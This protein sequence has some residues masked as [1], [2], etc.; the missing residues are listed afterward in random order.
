MS[1]ATLIAI[2][3][4]LLLAPAANAAD[5][6]E[7]HLS[8]PAALLYRFSPFA[9]GYIHGYEEGYSTGNLDF[10]LSTRRPQEKLKD[11]RRAKG[12]Q[13]QFGRKE[14]FQAGYREGFMAGYGDGR[15]GRSFRGVAAMRLAAERLGPASGET[16]PAVDDG[17]SSGYYAGRDGG[18]AHLAAHADFEVA[19]GPCPAGAAATTWCESFARGY[20]LGYADGYLAPEPA[21]Q[22][23]IAAK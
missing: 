8:D 15:E 22:P 9:H 12:Y 13:R 3:A 1:R 23:Q 10:Q 18:L 7:V 4:C 20:A 17:F 14:R 19:P 6:P 5:E 21:P 2:A 11:A 16:G